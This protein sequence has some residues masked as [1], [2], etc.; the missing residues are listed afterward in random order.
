MLK[1]KEGYIMKLDEIA[2]LIGGTVK[3]D[4]NLDIADIR[5]IEDAENGH[6]TFMANRKYL[7]QLQKGRASAVIVE[8]EMDTDK[9]QII[10][11]NP[12]LA[13]ARVLAHFYPETRPE[14]QVAS[15]AVLGKNVK[16]G[17]DVTVSP[18]VVVG[19]NVTIGDET[20]LHPGV[21]I[22]DRCRIGNGGI[23]HPN[24]T[25]YQGTVIGNHVILHAG[26]VV[27]ADGFGYTPDE[28]G[29]HFKINQV[30][31]VVIEDHVEV[32]A[33]TC[34]DRANIGTTLIREGTKIDNL[35]QIAHNCKIGE[36]SI[37]V[38]QVGLAGSCT[39]G[40]HVILAG[41][42]GVADHVTLG[43]L[44]VLTARAGTIRDIE[45]NAVH[46]GYP[47]VPLAI[48]K[49]Y[50]LTLPKLPELVRKVRDLDTRLNSI[51][52]QQPPG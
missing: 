4:G 39:L 38:A 30:G 11:V 36:H 24:V 1:N 51:E 41:Q 13:F 8:K 3:G 35:V 12:A 45:S 20:V 50:A 10:V 34:I 25:L 46:G 52:K 21:V 31:R 48:W 32:G 6:I 19:D 37:L 33:N 22:G 44:V 43:D 26:A 14:P 40:Q 29:H 17:K 2:K 23:L 49:K 7:D 9:S 15:T 5:S 18:L 47:S 27:G 28:K 16:L 42:A